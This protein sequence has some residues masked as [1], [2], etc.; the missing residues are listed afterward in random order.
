MGLGSGHSDVLHWFPKFGKSMQTARDDVAALIRKVSEPAPAPVVKPDAPTVEEDDEN[1]TL[2]KFKALMKEY[3][4]ELQDNDCGSWSKDARE[5]A[6]TTGLI[7]GI[8]TDKDGV[9]QYAWADSLT[10]EQMAALLYRFAQ[11]MG[12]V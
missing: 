10:R 11:M 2:D 9:S 7:N 5:W 4:A 1:M 12:R 6:I 3:R 8:G